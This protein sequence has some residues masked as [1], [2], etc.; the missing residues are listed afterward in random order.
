MKAWWTP[1]TEQLYLEN[2]RSKSSNTTKLQRHLHFNTGIDWCGNIIGSDKCAA[3]TNTWAQHYHK[4]CNN[5]YFYIICLLAFISFDWILI[6]IS[7]KSRRWDG[8]RGMGV[9]TKIMMGYR[10]GFCAN[11]ENIPSIKQWQNSS[12]QIEARDFCRC[13][14]PWMVSFDEDK[15]WTFIFNSRKFIFSWPLCSSLSQCV[16]I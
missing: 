6:R 16:T 2:L 12:W 9:K 4:K 14:P 10:C 3:S 11:T 8:K 5:I 15:I 1:A 7:T 13:D